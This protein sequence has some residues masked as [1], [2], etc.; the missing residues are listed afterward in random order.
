MPR[1]RHINE[2]VPYG[3]Q[4]K[5]PGGLIFDLTCIAT[6]ESVGEPNGYIKLY[7]GR[8]PITLL[9]YRNIDEGPADIYE[10]VNNIEKARLLCEVKE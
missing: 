7:M 2:F 6:I 9:F 4:L 8:E 10:I 3:T 5:S 1:L